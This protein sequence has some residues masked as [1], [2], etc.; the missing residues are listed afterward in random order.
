V[1][2]FPLACLLPTSRQPVRLRNPQPAPL[3]GDGAARK[4]FDG[5]PRDGFLAPPIARIFSP[6]IALFFWPPITRIAHPR[7]LGFC[8]R[9]VSAAS[10][11][12]NNPLRSDPPTDDGISRRPLRATLCLRPAPAIPPRVSVQVR[13]RAL[14]VQ[15]LCLFLFW[16]LYELF[17]HCCVCSVA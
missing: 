11:S 13:P 15:A 17:L 14:I 9:R 8:R 7:S 4:V 12:S 10:I 5:T 2:P 6:S 1:P 16:C 3:R